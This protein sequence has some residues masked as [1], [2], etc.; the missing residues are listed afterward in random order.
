M[1]VKYEDIVSKQES[2]SKKI[3]NFC[4]L[5][6]ET[7]CLTFHKNK[8]PIKTMSTAQARQPIYRTSLNSYEKF[9]PYLQT[10]NKIIEI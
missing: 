9:L 3:I 6:W 2:E 7:Q 8:A 5:E 4:G 10:L 1:D